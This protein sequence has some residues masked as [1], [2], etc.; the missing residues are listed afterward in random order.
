[1][2]SN[3]MPSL[4]VLMFLGVELVGA[5]GLIYWATRLAIRHELR[6]RGELNVER[7]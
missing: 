5:F 3:V 1:M 6:G 2:S 7:H 4:L